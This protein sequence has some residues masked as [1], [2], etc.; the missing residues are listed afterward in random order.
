R[1]LHRKGTLCKRRPLRQL[2]AQRSFPVH[3][4][5]DVVADA[6]V[7]SHATAADDRAATTRNGG[8]AATTRKRRASN[9]GGPDRAAAR[10]GTVWGS[11]P[12]GPGDGDSRG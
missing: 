5:A 3:W 2:F 7:P 12:N 4:V 6:S 10:L 11:R 8:R 9:R 1:S